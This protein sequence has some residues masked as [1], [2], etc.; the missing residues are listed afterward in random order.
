MQAIR[1]KYL[2]PTNT[3]PSRIKAIA[4]AGYVTVS[5]DHSLNSDENHAVAAIK[6]M[7]KF[8]W[9]GE[10]VGGSIGSDYV[11]VFSN[12][13]K[14]HRLVHKSRKFHAEQDQRWIKRVLERRGWALSCAHH[15]LARCKQNRKECEDE[16]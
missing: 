10:L 5:L 8:G 3:R 6:L 15:L 2:G 13:P 16:S 12:G 9:E 14:A 4:E 11:W 7:E 1:T